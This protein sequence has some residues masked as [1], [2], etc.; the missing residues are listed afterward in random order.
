M[1]KED[2]IKKISD[3]KSLGKLE[4]EINYNVIDLFQQVLDSKIKDKLS[5]LHYTFDELMGK[6]INDLFKKISIS[7][8]AKFPEFI[9]WYTEKITDKYKGKPEYIKKTLLVYFSFN[10]DASDR[11]I[12]KNFSNL[13]KNEFKNKVL[14]S[15]SSEKINFIHE[16]YRDLYY[17]F[18]SSYVDKKETIKE[19]KEFSSDVQVQILDKL[20]KNSWF[21]GDIY[22]LLK[23]HMNTLVDCDKN[24]VLELIFKYEPLL[25]YLDLFKEDLKNLINSNN[26]G[27][28]IFFKG[29]NHS[30]QKTHYIFKNLITDEQVYNKALDNI[31]TSKGNMSDKKDFNFFIKNI[32][33]SHIN[34]EKCLTDIQICII[35][36]RCYDSGERHNISDI[37]NVLK[38]NSPKLFDN[39]KDS[40]RSISVLVPYEG[41]V[42]DFSKKEVKDY[43]VA[44]LH[45]CLIVDLPKKEKS[46]RKMK[47]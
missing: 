14:P 29:V 42:L 27:S 39:V 12:E 6:E 21:D 8:F 43:F 26:I 34:K 1:K 46:P 24:K 25:D 5:F 45:N 17:Y 41:K 32:I 4:L 31:L 40:L 10:K 15:L 18:M 3:L 11:V 13:S 33:E 23:D 35:F 28:D 37:L 19:L 36:K 2:L 16:R 30:S 47:I 7:K 38:D 9:D 20:V 22:I 44:I